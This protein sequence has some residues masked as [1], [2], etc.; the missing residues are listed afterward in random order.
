MFEIIS[1]LPAVESCAYPSEL[2]R[3][4][5]ESSFVP[6]I[7]ESLAKPSDILG[8]TEQWSS[9]GESHVQ[10]K[11]KDCVILIIIFSVLAK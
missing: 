7:L 8:R 10:N 4:E 3:T 5:L 1:K 2:P 9:L 6:R 11:V